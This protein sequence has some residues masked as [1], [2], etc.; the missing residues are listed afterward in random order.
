MSAVDILAA[1][2]RIK[3]RSDAVA[4]LCNAAMDLAG[5]DTSMTLHFQS[6]S[7]AAFDSFDGSEHSFPEEEGHRAFQVKT[8]RL[9]DWPGVIELKLYLADEAEVPS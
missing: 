5:E 3:E 1:G 8:V 7:R 6:V 4:A 9:I 2:E